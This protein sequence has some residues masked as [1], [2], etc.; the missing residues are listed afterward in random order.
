M[1]KLA[2]LYVQNI[3]RLHREPLAIVLRQRFLVHFKGLAE[4]T[5]GDGDGVKV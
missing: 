1:D 2:R 4:L 3:L 5:E